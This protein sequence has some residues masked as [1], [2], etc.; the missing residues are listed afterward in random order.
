[1]CIFSTK[2]WLLHFQIYFC[3][4]SAIGNVKI[5]E[6]DPDG[7]FI[8]IL[9]CAPEK[10]ENIG[11]YVLKQDI[12]GQPVAEFCFPPETRMEANSTVTVSGGNLHVILQSLPCRLG[13]TLSLAVQNQTFNQ[14]NQIQNLYFQK[15]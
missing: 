13:F 3:S 8:K 14:I 6:V 7:H 9:N 4:F 12:Q 10:E 2:Q 1:M 5:S 15:G 11:N